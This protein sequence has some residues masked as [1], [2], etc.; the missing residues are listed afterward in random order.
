MRMHIKS[1]EKSEK[2]DEDRWDSIA[3]VYCLG[4]QPLQAWRPFVDITADGELQPPQWT[5]Q[6]EYE[7]LLHKREWQARSVYQYTMLIEIAGNWEVHESLVA[8]RAC[9]LVD[10]RYQEIALARFQLLCGMVGIDNRTTTLDELYYA[11]ICC[12][13]MH[14][15]LHDTIAAAKKLKQ[16]RRKEVMAEKPSRTDTF[17]QL[18]KNL[19][20]SIYAIHLY[21]PP[22]YACLR[23]KYDRGSQD[24]MDAH[25]AIEHMGKRLG[26]V[27]GQ[28]DRVLC[29]LTDP[30]CDKLK[31]GDL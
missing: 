21:W 18:A 23:E 7:Q 16:S 5:P 27:V 12:H 8:F 1:T 17:T 3:D 2:E 20:C 22:A 29:L 31:I 14:L 26:M 4:P 25:T 11:A 6:S 24:A 19:C 30:Q 15:H 28:L 10:L 13:S 9:A